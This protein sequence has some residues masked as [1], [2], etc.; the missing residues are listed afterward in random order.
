[1]FDKLQEPLKKYL[2]RVASNRLLPGFS[3][4]GKFAHAKVFVA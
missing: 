4:P 2:R 3:K 1:M